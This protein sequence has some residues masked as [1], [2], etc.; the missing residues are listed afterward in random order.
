MRKKIVGIGL[1]IILIL[2]IHMTSYAMSAYDQAHEDRANGGNGN[3]GTSS[4]STTGQQKYDQAHEDRANGGNGNYEASS[5]SSSS[6][7]QDTTGGS[8]SVSGSG[9]GGASYDLQDPISNPDFYKPKENVASENAEF[10]KMGSNIIATLRALGTLVMVVS[11]MVMGIRYMIAS[12]AD[13]ALYKET[14]V[15]YLIGAIMVFTIP[16][17]VGIIYELIVNNF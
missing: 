14:M 10:I 15:P 11:L 1:I 12:T 8:I 16:Q 3:H 7:P 5:S 13:K 9:E 17:I 2:N 4:S 6:N